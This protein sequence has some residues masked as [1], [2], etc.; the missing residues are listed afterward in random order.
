LHSHPQNN[1]QAEEMVKQI[2]HRLCI[3][4]LLAFVVTLSPAM[5]RIAHAD[6]GPVV[7]SQVYGGG[8]S[9]AGV[10]KNDYVELLN[11]SDSPVDITGWAIQY[12]S[13]AATSGNYQV[14]TLS[15]ILPAGHYW[16]VKLGGGSGKATLPTADITG[17]LSLSNS[18]GRVVLTG[19]NIALPA[20]PC[21]AGASI[22]DAV[23]YGDTICSETA[24]TPSLSTASAAF[25]RADGCFDTNNNLVDFTL[26]P[27]VPRNSASPGAS[28]GL[29]I[30]KTAPSNIE[31]S[32]NITYTLVVTN[33]LYPAAPAADLSITDSLPVGTDYVAGSASDGGLM[34]GTVLS[35]TTSNL[36]YG[37]SIT[38]TFRVVAPPAA[39]TVVNSEYYVRAMSPA[40]AAT[41]RPIST[42]VGTPD[43][44]LVKVLAGQSGDPVRTVTFTLSYSNTGT[45]TATGAT[46]VDALPPGLAYLSASGSPSSDGQTI[47]WTLGTLAPGAGSSITLTTKAV[48]AGRFTN[49]AAISSTAEESHLSNNL[50]TAQ[51]SLPGA[52]PFVGASG[53]AFA[54]PG[55]ALTYVISVGNDGSEPAY[56]V[57][58][59]DTL[60]A[61]IRP[62]AIISDT[63]GLL[64]EDGANARSWILS[65]L[66]PDSLFTFNLGVRIPAGLGPNSSLTNTLFVGSAVARGD[67][68]GNNVSPATSRVALRIHSI[69]GAA[70]LSPYAGMRIPAVPGIVTA[71][72]TN[73]FEL[74]D[75]SPDA[76]PASSEG[77]MVYTGSPPTGVAVGDSLIVT[78]TV[79][80]YRSSASYLTVTELTSPQIA[81]LSTGSSLPEPVIIGEDGRVPPNRAIAGPAPGNSV[82]ALNYVFDSASHAI[83]F[84]E[85][86][87]SM[88]VVVRHAVAVGPSNDYGENPVLPDNGTGAVTRTLR[89]GVVVGPNSFNP[90]RLIL[91]DEILKAADQAM[92]TMATGDRIS[93]PITG[94]LDYNSGRYVLQ[95]L[96][97]PIVSPSDLAKSAVA[98]S[99]DHRLT[100]GSFNVNN[101]SPKDPAGKF[102]E[103]AAI[104]VDWMKAPDIVSVEEIQDN[105]GSVNDGTVS[106]T[107]TYTTLLASIVKGG[108]PVYDYRSIDPVDNQDGGAPGGNIRVGFLYR[109]DRVKFVDRPGGIAT[110]DTEAVAGTNG[111][112]VRLTF[113]PGRISP[114]NSAFAG[115]RKPLAGEFEF[116]GHQL[117]V[118]ANHFNSKGTDDPLMG[119]RQ[120]PALVSETQRLQQASAV[121]GFVKQILSLDPS[122]DVIV[123]G[124]LNDFE[125]AA[126][127][128]ILKGTMLVDLLEM[129]PHEERYTYIY[130]GNS[131]ALD[132]TLVSNHLMTAASPTFEV[133]H[134]NAEYPP[135][136]RAS[137]HDPTV[138]SF[139]FT[140]YNRYFLPLVAKRP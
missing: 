14:L 86:L 12:G 30:A 76:D 81:C 100:V 80:E 128:A 122:A 57:R 117:F 31:P 70:H 66:A 49:H 92:P 75:P 53:P 119:W 82:E 101:L 51:F 3:V 71:L 22:V 62:A 121:H 110:S 105:N 72:R 87:E 61:E 135:S 88:L 17:T 104:L 113:S 125:F 83:D 50:A 118:I 6:P 7:I 25:R 132:H 20:S 96:A 55:Q 64:A 16:L 36:A 131:E 21:P 134:V 38:R 44:G 84:F 67:Y 138:G 15:G 106:A 94:V 111:A 133:A 137:D 10:Y 65:Q 136:A 1:T 2:P 85:S 29:T 73:G 18:A 139:G 35:W 41:G 93:R 43:L 74:Q 114:A 11:R 9:A 127:L 60:P 130:E 26:G 99:P 77:I 102:A 34:L 115:S 90:Q 124:D 5:I 109:P 39:G 8:G 78:G 32:G 107:R 24:P 126:P 54:Y 42:T 46:V 79:S 28:C 56:G 69:Q 45:G 48:Y 23:G 89:G 98:T 140:A 63:S 123:L 116:R 27:P 59:T 120:P 68:P 108:G 37:A 40:A 112:K 52:D 47:T 97:P 95:A 13:A 58:I 91:D 103:L 4:M 129:Q 33:L 19:N